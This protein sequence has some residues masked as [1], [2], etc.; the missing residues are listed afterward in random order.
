MART[1]RNFEDRQTQERQWL[2]EH[3]WCD[4]YGEADL[5][6]TEPAEY[7]EGG[8]VFV[9]GKCVRCGQRVVSSVSE[10]DAKS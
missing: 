3:T 8:R 6:L 1:E 2:V 10:R 7:E 9:E 4:H 5:G